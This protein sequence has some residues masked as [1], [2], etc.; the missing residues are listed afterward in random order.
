MF[1]EYC[2]GLTWRMIGSMSGPMAGAIGEGMSDVCA[3]M[4]NGDDRV[5]EY[6]AS[7]PIGTRRAPYAGYPRTYGDVTG[8]EVH[9]D[10]EIYGAIG[11]RLIELFGEAGRDTLFSYLVQGMNYTP[12]GPTYEQMRDG[13]LQAVSIGGGTA[14]DT[15][16]VWQAFAQ[17]GVGEGAQATVRGKR[18]TIRESFIVP[19]TVCQ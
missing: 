9:D 5:G 1:H 2:H 3:L 11:W 14:A 7:D 13:I 19:A 8:A 17:F 12:A 18:V 16:K 10:G 15:C 4:M 6:S